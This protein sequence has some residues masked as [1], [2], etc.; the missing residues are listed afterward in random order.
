MALD[1]LPNE[2]L[3]MIMEYIGDE[4]HL[5]R[6]FRATRALSLVNHR[7]R[8]FTLPFLYRNLKLSYDRFHFFKRMATFSEAWGTNYLKHV[9]YVSLFRC[10]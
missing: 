5:P 9:R 10:T 2:L 3:Y 4:R 7:L 6:K 8:E 1:R